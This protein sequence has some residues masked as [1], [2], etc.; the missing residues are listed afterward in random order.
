[1]RIAAFLP[2]F[3]GKGEPPPSPVDLIQSAYAV[4][5]YYHRLTSDVCHL[6]VEGNRRNRLMLA[7]QVGY[8]TFLEELIKV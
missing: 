2:P 6:V 1:M 5:E 4:T 7:T 8:I 3:C